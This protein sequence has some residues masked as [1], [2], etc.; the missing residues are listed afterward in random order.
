[1]GGS[2]ARPLPSRGWSIAHIRGVR[3]SRIS[4]PR[5]RKRGSQHDQG[6][7][8]WGHLLI[9]GRM[10]SHKKAICWLLF[11][12]THNVVSAPVLRFDVLCAFFNATEDA[13]PRHAHPGITS[14]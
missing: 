3:V 11:G 4:L 13:L 2:K 7:H 1:M 6:G 12:C 8:N 10:K 5:A 9:F 14:C